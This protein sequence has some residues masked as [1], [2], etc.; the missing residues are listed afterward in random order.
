MNSISILKDFISLKSNLFE[1]NGLT[2]GTLVCALV[3]VSI[4]SV[5]DW[6][7]SR[8]ENH[9]HKNWVPDK[10]NALD[11]MENAETIAVQSR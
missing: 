5:V 9:S 11:E 10:L 8:Y 2:I 6:F 7:V 4:E 3:K 1:G